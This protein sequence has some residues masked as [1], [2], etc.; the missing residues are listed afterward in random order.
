MDKDLSFE[1]IN[2]GRGKP[3]KLIA[4]INTIEKL[5]NKKARLNMKPIQQGDV[6]QT[7]A[8]ISKAKL[9]LDYNP[10]ID[11]SEGIK[12]FINWYKDYHLL[13]ENKNKN[14]KNAL[15]VIHNE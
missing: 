2:L 8:D 6:N 1:I 11:I 3:I 15:K 14:L 9:L 10:K 7:W 5:L 4:F 13:D 12:D